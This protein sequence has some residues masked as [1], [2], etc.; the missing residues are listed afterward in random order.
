MRRLILNM[1]LVMVATMLA[2]VCA[3]T[4][5]V[6]V[7]LP[8][9]PVA[10]D[11]FSLTVTVNNPDGN[12]VPPSAPELDGCTFLGGPG[13][14][15]MSSTSIVNGRMQSTSSTGYSFTYRADREGAVKVPAIEVK[16]SGK[17]LTTRPGQFTILKASERNNAGQ[18]QGQGAFPGQGRGNSQYAGQ[19]G[20]FKAGPND[21]FIRMELSTNSVYENQAVECVTKLYSIN[22]QV[23][24]IAASSLPTF[25]GCLIENLPTSTNIEWNREH[26]NGENYYTAIISRSL[27][28]PQRNG[29]LAIGEGGEYSVNVYREMIVDDFPFPRRVMDDKDV[30][31]KPRAATLNVKPLPQPAPAGFNGAVG[32]FEA[33]TRLV[34]NTFKTNEAATMIYTIKGTGNIKYLQAPKIDLPSE[35]EL[36]DPHVENDAKVS[37]HNMTGT[38]TVEYT[39]VPQSV[40]TFHIGGSEFTYFDPSRAEYVSIDLPSYDVEVAQGA[41]VSNT[42]VS[43]G[44]KQ[45]IE[46]KNTDIH[47]IKTGANKP[48]S[49]KRYLAHNVMFWVAFPATLI[50]LIIVL[51]ASSRSRA[52]RADVKTQRLNKAGKVA[53]RRLAAA[54]KAL[55]QKQYEAFYAEL[56]NALQGYLGDKLQIA[57]SQ[58]SR[59]NINACLIADGADTELT[60]RL[61][62][63]LDECEMAR[64]TPQLSPEQADRTFNEATDIINRI[65]NIKRR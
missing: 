62:S 11:R 33:E 55:K 41:N 9:N 36:Y 18:N 30:T 20:D 8:R 63:V 53:R 58:L 52:N 28:Y 19:G 32:R 39:F 47:F 31:V 64:Y 17:T 27:L 35:F 54:S 7:S 6:E 59:D 40:G 13:V 44:G 50:L 43:F 14:S 61:T 25:D 57:S 49:T 51:A 37:G 46:S 16:V 56:L 24:A 2:S 34:G 65:E 12:V 42:A 22:A 48:G 45:E 10:G 29:K 3:Q 60:D 21:L 1:L 4:P 23:R 38:M 5:S 15:T 26:F